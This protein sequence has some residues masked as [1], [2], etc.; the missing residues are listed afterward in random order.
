MSLDDDKWNHVIRSLGHDI[1]H[2]PKNYRP[3]H[4]ISSKVQT[5]S[6]NPKDSLRS[7][8]PKSKDPKSA[9]PRDNIAKPVKKEDEKKKRSQ[10]HR[11]EYIRDWKEQFSATGVNIE[12]SK[13][14][15]RLNAS[16]VIR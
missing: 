10:R 3:F 7:K 9:L 16:T 11:R 13:K 4:N 5:Q 2:Y 12:A 1:T 6:S 15:S 14:R 8:N